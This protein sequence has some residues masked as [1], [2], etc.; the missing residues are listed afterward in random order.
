MDLLKLPRAPIRTVDIFRLAQ[1]RGLRL[2]FLVLRFAEYNLVDY[3]LPIRRAWFF[4]F[5]L[6]ATCAAP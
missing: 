2:L 1:K 5:R 4:L 6:G 3:S